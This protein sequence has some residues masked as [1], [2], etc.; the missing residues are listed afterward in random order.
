V[1]SQYGLGYLWRWAL[2]CVGLIAVAA[3][4]AVITR[5]GE[6]STELS[7][8]LE[9]Q[10]RLKHLGTVFEIYRSE[11]PQWWPQSSE[12]AVQSLLDAGLVTE[13]TS[14]CPNGGQYLFLI[15][16]TRPEAQAVTDS[17]VVWIYEPVS[18]HGGEGGNLLFMDG[19]G[20]FM[21]VPGYHAVLSESRRRLGLDPSPPE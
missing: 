7:R 15:P 4:L 20:D 21:R 19:H 11:N 5:A 16:P 3:V 8:R 6:R 10:A 17:R 9:C 1:S 2:T 12:E 18:N 13:D 14:R